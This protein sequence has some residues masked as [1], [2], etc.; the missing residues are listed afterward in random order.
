MKHFLVLRCRDQLNVS[1]GLKALCFSWA[2]QRRFLERGIIFQTHESSNFVS[3]HLKI[4]KDRLLLKIRFNAL[5]SKLLYS[6]CTLERSIKN[7]PISRTGYKKLAHFLNG[8]SILGECFL[9]RGANL[10]SRAAHTY[11]KNTQLPPPPSSPHGSNSQAFCIT[12]LIE[13][14]IFRWTTDCPS[15]GEVSFNYSFTSHDDH[16]RSLFYWLVTK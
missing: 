7:W 14:M 11:P 15:V 3:S 9:E 16:S 8:V 6:C 2:T 13:R 1:S 10:E 5:T 12:K 4:F